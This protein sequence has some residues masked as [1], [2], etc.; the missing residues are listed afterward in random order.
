MISFFYI[1]FLSRQVVQGVAQD[2]PGI[3]LIHRG[4]MWRL[5]IVNIELF[6][7][8]PAVKRR[9]LHLFVNAQELKA[10]T[11]G[12]NAVSLETKCLE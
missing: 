3:G 10:V 5:N 7:V 11:T 8:S 12:K 6:N 1:L 9:A 4:E 2:A